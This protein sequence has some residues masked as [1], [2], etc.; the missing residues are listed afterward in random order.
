[1][2]TVFKKS[3]FFVAYL[4]FLHKE[5]R[6]N[7]FVNKLLRFWVKV[8]YVNFLINS[9]FVDSNILLRVLQVNGRIDTARSRFS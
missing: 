9:Y 2:G 3:G 5:V 6:K 7:F 1:M 4:F 8:S